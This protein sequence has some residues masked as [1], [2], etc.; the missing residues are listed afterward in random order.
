MKKLLKRV[1]AFLASPL[2]TLIVGLW[3]VLS[4]YFDHKPLTPLE[5]F[6]LALGVVVQ[7]NQAWIERKRVAKLEKA[8]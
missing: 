5:A 7:A 8:A 1:Q 6:C 2:M 3:F 4:L